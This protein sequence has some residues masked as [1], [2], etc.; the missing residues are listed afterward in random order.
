MEEEMEH[1]S[2]HS[3]PVRER[4]PAR[5]TEPGESC[6]RY[7]GLLRDFYKTHPE[8]PAI[9][10]SFTAA[11]SLPQ[12]QR[13]LLVHYSDMTSTLSRHYGEPIALRLLERHEGSQWYRRHIVLETATTRRPV[14]YGAMRVLLPLLSEAARAEVLEAKL[15]LGS[16]L[17]RHKLTYR[18]CPGGFFSI[19][20]NHLIE[21]A[22]KLSW[23][24]RLYGRCNCMSDEVGRVVAEVIEI[25]P[26]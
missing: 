18:H 5:A 15:P 14:E 3:L 12:P 23:P 19:H 7:L 20:T 25:L 4:V 21:Q 22:L 13:S 11:E 8:R 9:D 17:A 6:D 10:V 26:P 16:I 1:R 24:Q 2:K